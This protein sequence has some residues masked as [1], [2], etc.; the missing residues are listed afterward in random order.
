MSRSDYED[1][2]AQINM[3]ERKKQHRIAFKY[4]KC[5][6][7]CVLFWK[8]VT[9]WKWTL[10]FEQ[11]CWRKWHMHKQIN[12]NNNIYRN[13]SFLCNIYRCHRNYN[14]F[15][16]NFSREIRAY[17]F[18]KSSHIEFLISKSIFFFFSSHCYR[19]FYSCRKNR[20]EPNKQRGSSMYSFVFIGIRTTVQLIDNAPANIKCRRQLQKRNPISN[21]WQTTFGIEWV[22]EK[23][24]KIK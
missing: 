11:N 17:P 18:S 3:K 23:G 6:S 21:I 9:F 20:Y 14:E 7:D 16:T 5:K 13:I 8:V 19:L 24:K 22:D 1:V 12:N 2:N 10:L 4:N 15:W